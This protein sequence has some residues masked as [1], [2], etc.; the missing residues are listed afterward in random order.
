MRLFS[1]TGQQKSYML[2]RQ[3]L[4][5][6]R[7]V[8]I[9]M[10][11]L[12]R[13]LPV[14]VDCSVV[15]RYAI[16][17]PREFAKEGSNVAIDKARSL[18]LPVQYLQMETRG[19]TLW[20]RSSRRTSFSRIKPAAQTK[21]GI[22][23][24]Q[25]ILLLPAAQG[26]LHRRVHVDLGH[27]LEVCSPT[28]HPTELPNNSQAL[29][30]LL[31]HLHIHPPFPQVAWALRDIRKKQVKQYH[32]RHCQLRLLILQKMPS[33]APVLLHKELRAARYLTFSISPMILYQ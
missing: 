11:H 31:L 12:I 2:T 14:V 21:P 27:L 10:T 5:H 1:T 18:S 16:Q 22:H 29:L 19:R 32:Q 28:N 15:Q 7:K 6:T 20:S 4:L 33:R 13:E 26:A 9:T 30:A 3:Q 25:S 24:R 17:V 8:Q 23:R